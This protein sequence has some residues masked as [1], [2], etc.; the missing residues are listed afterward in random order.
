MFNIK[1]NYPNVIDALT[2]QA[3]PPEGITREVLLPPDHVAERSGD[4]VITPHEVSA[5]QNVDM[6]GDTAAAAKSTKSKP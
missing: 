6:P 5:Q 1:P 4:V 3:M 2:G